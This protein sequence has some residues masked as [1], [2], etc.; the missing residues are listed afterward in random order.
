[1]QW[2]ERGTV[3]RERLFTGLFRERGYG[4]LLEKLSTNH[5]KLLRINHPSLRRQRPPF[6]HWCMD[7]PWA[8]GGALKLFQSCHSIRW[9][10][11][12][13][14]KKLCIWF[15]FFRVVLIPV[16]RGT[17]TSFLGPE[18]QKAYGT[19]VHTQDLTGKA[20]PGLLMSLTLV[21][22]GASQSGKARVS[23]LR[24]GT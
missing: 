16:L 6:H 2:V 13:N 14:R 12:L 7:S 10:S 23:W 3:N 11:V 9:F 15:W 19:H 21:S 20:S 18:N 24:A 1:M 5:W 17:N 22:E 8:C 4:I